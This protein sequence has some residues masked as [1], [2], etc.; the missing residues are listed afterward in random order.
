MEKEDAK[1][2][3]TAE[4]Q[5]KIGVQL[6]KSAKTYKSNDREKE[7]LRIKVNE[8]SESK[9]EGDIVR[10]PILQRKKN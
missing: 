2:K 6:R 5:L 3:L 4:E 7:I 1:L 9:N 8:W 10:T